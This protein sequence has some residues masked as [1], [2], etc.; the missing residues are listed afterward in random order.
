ML[1]MRAFFELNQKYHMLVRKDLLLFT[2]NKR[3]SLA[4]ARVAGLRNASGCF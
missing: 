3:K 1:S 4:L 2:N